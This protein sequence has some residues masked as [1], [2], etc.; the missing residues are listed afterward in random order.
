MATHR[1]DALGENTIGENALGENALGGNALGDNA[2]G[3]NT[4]GENALGEN[5]LGEN[6]L[7]DNTLGENTLGEN[8]LGENTLGENILGEN[9]LE[10]NTLGENILGENTLGDNTLGENTL[11]DNTLGENTLGEN[12]LGENTLG[13]NT[14]GENTL[15]EN[16]LGENTLGEN[17]LGENTLGENTLGE[18]TLGENTLG[19]N[20]LGENALGENALG[21][22]ALGENALGE[23]TLGENTL[24]ENTLGENTLGENT[25]GEN[26]LGENTLGENALGENALGEN[27]L[28]E[29]ALGENALGENA[30][31]ENALGENALGENALGENT[32]GENT[33]GE[34]A[35]G[36]NALGENT[37]GEN[38]LGENALGENT[39]G[40]NTL[41]ENA[42]G[43]NALGE[44]TLG[45]NALGENAL[46]EN[47][48]GENTLG[49]N[50]L[51]ENA[52]GENTLGENTL[53]ENALGENALGEN[54]LGENALGP[55]CVS[56]PLYSGPECVSIPCLQVLNVSPFPC[57]Q[58]LNVLN[59]VQSYVTLRVPLFV[60][61]VFHSPSAPG[62][63]LTFDLRS[64]LRMTFTY[65]TSILWRDGIGSPPD[66]P[67]QG[68]LHPTSM[69]INGEGRL[70]VTFRTEARFRGHFILSHPGVSGSSVVTSDAHSG[71]LF[72]LFLVR[73]ETTLTHTLQTWS[74]VSQLAVRDYSGSYTVVLLPCLIPEGEHTDPPVCHRRPPL[75]FSLD[76]RFQQVSD[77]VPVEFSLNTILVLLSKRE[78]WLSDGSMGFGQDDDIA[79][80]K[81]SVIYGRVMVDPV[82]SLGNS[83]QCH[84][85]QVFLCTG[86]DGYI[87]KYRPSN[88]EY[89]CLADAS[90]L[91]YRLK[92]LDQAEPES[93]EV[94]FGG[95]RFE[96]RLAGDTPGAFPLVSQ[97]DADGFSLSSAPLFQV[98]AGHEWYIHAVYTVRSR[99]HGNRNYNN[100][101]HAVGKRSLFLQHHVISSGGRQKR[102][103]PEEERGEDQ[104][105]GTNLR[106]V[107][108]QRAPS[109]GQSWAEGP[110]MDWELQERGEGPVESP[111][112]ETL[113]GA[114]GSVTLAVVVLVVA[115]LGGVVVYA[116]FVR[117][118]AIC[119]ADCL[120]SS[121]LSSSS[122]RA[123]GPLPQRGK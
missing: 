61:Y 24:G 69:R 43:E 94:E 16:T 106:H 51:G 2:L 95:I 26:T 65:D 34:N 123:L 108:L 109:L 45:E 1:D 83:F 15:G 37:L 48:L 58:V 57:L 101:N 17:T 75:S 66:A 36:E 60:S 82:Q 25:L 89:G 118:E 30:L 20:T 35:L 115:C 114:T 63:W 116:V 42:L 97:P 91:L 112:R 110:L 64:D 39:L 80:S 22:N 103:A 21:E 6:A 38:A 88:G 14:L 73:S 100:H 93:Q 102:A 120:S 70:V 78:L 27:A 55:E 107:H 68:S 62:G 77:P 119:S 50:A 92:I 12:T 4:L 85:Q 90:S 10:E 29:N 67:L 3:D 7:G 31:G 72:S 117:S 41:G 23:N 105:R 79:F 40:E 18:N 59:A 99:D 46:G 13:E 52:L 84:I 53:G 32:L 86:A 71:L 122:R 47:T 98:A 81:D 49:E 5:A 54:A 28:G 121:S 11:G 87:P 56:I 111:E 19:E 8:T 104:D 113:D 44:N 96:A 33:L 9:T 76:V 74:F